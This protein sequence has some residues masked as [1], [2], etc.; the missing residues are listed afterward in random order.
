MLGEQTEA[1]KAAACYGLSWGEVP[2]DVGCCPPKYK[3]Y[4][5]PLKF[6]SSNVLL[7]NKVYVYFTDEHYKLAVFSSGQCRFRNTAIKSEF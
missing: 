6:A 1:E 5:L 2:D 3:L 7:K 4:I